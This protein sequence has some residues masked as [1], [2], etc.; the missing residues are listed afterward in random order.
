MRTWNRM[1][2][3]LAAWGLA[4]PAGATAPGNLDERLVENVVHVCAN[5]PRV[6]CR[7]LDASG[8]AFTAC[9]CARDPVA[10]SQDPPEPPEQRCLIDFIP[11]A[12]LRGV[13]TLVADD[14]TQDGD[15]DPTNDDDNHAWTV[16]LELEGGGP[17]VVIAETYYGD[18]AGSIH[19][20]GWN[21]LMDEGE[22]FVIEPARSVGRDVDISPLSSGGMVPVLSMLP[23]QERLREIAQQRFGRDGVPILTQLEPIPR[24]DVD[25]SAS[26]GDSTL[27]SVARYRVT[28]RFANGT[29]PVE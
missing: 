14:F 10:C 15:D 23:I 28:I 8:H 13:A 17:G 24:L 3:A 9:E 25:E 27:G 5:R 26:G 19:I 29:P 4:Q 1:L 21:P 6:Q 18:D 12:T 16:L 20:G 2:V 7:E 22:V 11:G